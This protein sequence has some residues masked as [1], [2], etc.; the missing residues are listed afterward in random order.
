MHP[1]SPPRKS[2]VHG[3]SH[4]VARPLFRFDPGWLFLIAGIAAVGA[5]VLV[6]AAADLDEARWQR[7]KALAIE[8]HRLER[9]DHYGKYLAAVQRADEDVVLSLTATQLNRSP[10][11]RI[12]LLPVPEPGR[13]SASPFPALEPGPLKEP[14]RLPLQRNPSLLQRLTTSDR[15]RLWM[16]AGGM[17]C[18]LIGLLPPVI[19]RWTPQKP[20]ADLPEPAAG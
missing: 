20:G 18:M 7:N 17:L 3:P 8:R 16:L 11:G 9:L 6:P 13:T 14:D 5:T 15:H 12:P 4:E 2:A 19:R 1:V 10:V